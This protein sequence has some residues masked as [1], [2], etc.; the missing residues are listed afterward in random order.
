[1]VDLDLFETIGAGVFGAVYRGQYKGKII[2]IKVVR[3]ESENILSDEEYQ[4][5]LTEGKIMLQLERH[6]NVI[7]V[8]YICINRDTPAIIME[9]A[10]MGTLRD[11]LE[12]LN[13][14]LQLNVILKLIQGI[15]CGLSVL[16]KHGVVH[17]DIA[18]RNIL[19]GENLVP[20][21]SDFGLSRESDEK[22][23]SYSSRGLHALPVKWMAPEAIS[24]GVFSTQTDMWS[25]GIVIWEI[26]TRELPH[27]ERD[28]T[29]CKI[30]IRDS[31]LTPIIPKDF[32]H[33][34]I[35]DIMRQC[36]YKDPELRTSA[37]DISE[38]IE[39]YF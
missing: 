32:E 18:A 27:N 7:S 35:A 9:F 11:Y 26:A 24:E 6:P 17:R 36:W 2:A 21:V 38:F 25:F 23:G 34:V 31:F 30:L 16:H 29:E 20:K 37:K 39:D 15:A 5:F 33:T 12:K 1:M 14:N 8:E 19:L 28:S 4:E 13:E 3:T 22:E 10:P